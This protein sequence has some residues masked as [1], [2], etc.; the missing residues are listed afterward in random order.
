M[1]SDKVRV[2]ICPLDWGL[3]H[4][5][6]CIPL[7]RELIENGA[8][9]IVGSDGLQLTLLQTE[10][11][12]IE[13]VR[14]PGYNV[15]YGKRLP[16]AIKLL[17]D[18]PRLLRMI[19]K[20]HKEMN[21]IIRELQPDMVISDNRYGLW[22]K[23]VYSVFITHQVNIIAPAALMLYAP[24]L[25]LATRYHMKHYDESWIPDFAGK[26][27]LSGKL[28]HGRNLPQNTSYIGLLSRFDQLKA[29][30]RSQRRY[31]I[32]AIVS[33][34]EP[35]RTIF[36]N[37]LLARLPLPDKHC[38]LLRGIPGDTQIKPL[39]K[40]LDIA[41]H[42]ETEELGS[43][44]HQKPVVICRAGYSTLMDIAYTGNKAVLIPT[45][46]QTEQEFL[47][48]N[49]HKAGIY[50]ARKQKDFDLSEAY[51]QAI[52]CSGFNLP[53]NH[54][55]YQGVIYKLMQKLKSE[56]SIHPKKG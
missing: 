11:P 10:F 41:D 7:I 46:G 44:I 42:L 45:P 47:A 9:V 2:L 14:L 53:K 55:Y 29:T 37:K 25:R 39:R 23:N 22:N 30:K 21:K 49:L 4:A 54:T 6:R 50:A 36:E 32:V 16:V 48:K 33:G 12:G 52:A 19:A 56:K 24:V 13:F 40:G 35:Q 15:S 28:S 5:T 51:N 27:N 38:L 43:I 3:G 31:D 1:K 17:T 26:L 20:E 18:A 34:P 8:E